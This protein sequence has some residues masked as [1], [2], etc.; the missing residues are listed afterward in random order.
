MVCC[1]ILGKERFVLRRLQHTRA[2]AC[3][4]LDFLRQHVIT[5]PISH[6]KYINFVGF[7][8]VPG[9]KG[10]TYP[11]KWVT[12]ASR[13]EM[14]AHYAGWEPEVGE[15]LAVRRHNS[16]TCTLADVLVCVLYAR[17]Y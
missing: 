6:G 2:A 8:T 13:D 5:Y 11:R 4:N 1:S 12:D 10:T 7:V 16:V 9:A 17:G 15:M 3:V 14:A